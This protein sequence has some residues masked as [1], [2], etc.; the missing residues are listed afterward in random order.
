MIWNFPADGYKFYWFVQMKSFQT[1][2]NLKKKTPSMKYIKVNIKL[3]KKRE[4]YWRKNMGF[5][6]AQEQWLRTLWLCHE[7]KLL[8]G[9]VVK[10]PFARF[11]RKVFARGKLLPGKLW[12]F[13]PLQGSNPCLCFRTCSKEKCRHK[14]SSG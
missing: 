10:N 8:F 7:Q 2:S 6:L 14:H 1:V 11:I 13:V 9:F 12:V 4:E 3:S 5:S